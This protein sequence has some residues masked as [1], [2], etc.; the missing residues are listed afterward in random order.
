[1]EPICIVRSS[2]TKAMDREL[3]W[4]SIFYHKKSLIKMIV[5][6]AILLFL[7][8]Y[9]VIKVYPDTIRYWEYLETDTQ[10]LMV[11]CAIIYGTGLFRV[12]FQAH[13]FANKREKERRKILGDKPHCSE[14]L[15]Y[16]DR[17][18][19]RGNS[20]PTED[21]IIYA[22]V[23]KVRETA[24]LYIIITVNNMWY[25]FDKRGFVQGSWEQV[26]QLLGERVK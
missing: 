18:L 22:G 11:A 1:M 5:S 20:S 26:L 9:L 13:S 4:T 14:L 21:W 23:K 24:H 6:T 19:C 3:Y 10:I 16:N 8:I 12:V 17:F 25:S 2:R 7:A 15:F